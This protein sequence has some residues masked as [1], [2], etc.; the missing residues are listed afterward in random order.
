MSDKL[1]VYISPDYSSK[2]YA[3]LDLLH[4]GNIDVWLRRRN[5]YLKA[6]SKDAALECEAAKLLT[7]GVVGTG[8]VLSINPLMWIA[9]AIGAVGYVWTVFQEYQDTNA[10]RPIPMYRGRLTDI[11]ARFEGKEA[12]QRRCIQDDI[13]YLANEEKGEALLLNYMFAE[14]SE[15]IIKAPPLV[16]FDLYR[17]I[18]SQYYARMNLVTLDEVEQY[19]NCAVGADRKRSMEELAAARQNALEEAQSKPKD[20]PAE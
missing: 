7:V 3:P 16:R 18:V 9:I 20:I 1:E 13:E 2:H 8:I 5:E 15:L 12:K 19:L 17:H 14:L 4:S 6:K 10:I 11:L